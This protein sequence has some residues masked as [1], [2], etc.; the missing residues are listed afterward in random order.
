MGGKFEVLVECVFDEYWV[1]VYVWVSKL[2][3]FGL[4]IIFEGKVEVIMVVCYGEFFEFEF[5]KDENVLDILNDIGYMFL[6][7]YIDCFDNEV[8]CECY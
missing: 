1:F 5:V 3:K 6:L 8:D 4:K 7:F 2:L